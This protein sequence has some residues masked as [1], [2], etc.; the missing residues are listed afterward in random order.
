MYKGGRKQILGD[1]FP[2]RGGGPQPLEQSTFFRQNIF[3]KKE[4]IFFSSLI[5][6]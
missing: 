6:P 1:M 3:I 2:I 4:K 5:F